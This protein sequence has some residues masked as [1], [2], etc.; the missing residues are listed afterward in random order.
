ML[1]PLK[2]PLKGGKTPKAMDAKLPNM[3]KIITHS[4]DDQ[5]KNGVG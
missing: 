5:F 2:N 4:T 3:N 1:L